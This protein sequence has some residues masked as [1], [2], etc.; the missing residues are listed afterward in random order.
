MFVGGTTPVDYE[1]AYE[2]LERDIGKMSLDG[3]YVHASADS[4]FS[5]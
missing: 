3:S 2:E 5:T 4:S 1:R